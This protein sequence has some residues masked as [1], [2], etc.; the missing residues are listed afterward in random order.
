MPLRSQ[1]ISSHQSPRT[2][3]VNI[4]TQA[5]GYVSSIRKVMSLHIWPVPSIECLF[6]GVGS[7]RDYLTQSGSSPLQRAANLSLSFE[8]LEQGAI[9]IV[10]VPNFLKRNEISDYTGLIRLIVTQSI[11]ESTGFGGGLNIFFSEIII[12]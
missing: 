6:V 3:N 5:Q 1:V 4:L 7:F 2:K 12:N 8:F 10:H 11:T 9:F